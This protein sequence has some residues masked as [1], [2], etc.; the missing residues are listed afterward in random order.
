[1]DK[2][3]IVIPAYNESETI[4]AV[5]RQWH[6][7]AEMAGGESRL[8]V[9]DDGSKDDTFA[10]LK[11]L[12]VSLPRLTALTKPNAGHGP[13]CTYGYYYALDHGADYVFQTDSDG[14]TLPQE[15][16]RFWEL[17]EQYDMVIGH[18]NKRQDGFSRVFVT[19]VLK[20]AIRLTFH[21]KVTDANTPFRLMKASFLTECL[22]AIPQGF[23]LPNVLISTF[24]VKRGKSV[25]FLPITFLPRQGGKNSINLKKIF[26]I[27]RKAFGDFRT[28]SRSLKQ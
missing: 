16:T 28:I 20:H 13:T 22:N 26:K 12:S 24:A 18:R 21:V 1:M 3:Y 10:K 15:F 7:V 2:L 25:L 17:R 11:A 9:I 8:V 4:D 6:A 5:A 27:G 23:N 14:Q 19:K